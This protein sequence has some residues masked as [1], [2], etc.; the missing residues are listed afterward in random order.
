MGIQIGNEELR[1]IIAQHIRNKTGASVVTENIYF[2]VVAAED[3]NK[4]DIITYEDISISSEIDEA[5]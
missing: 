1:E 2:R 3:C 5:P 4:G